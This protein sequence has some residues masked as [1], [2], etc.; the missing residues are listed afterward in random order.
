[1]SIT[2]I[3]KELKVSR[4][5]FSKF[6]QEQGYDTNPKK[7]KH[8][9]NRR[10]F[11]DIDTEEKLY[12]LGFLFADGCILESKKNGKKKGMVMEVTVADVDVEHLYKLCDSIGASRDMV[13]SKTVKL[14]DKEYV[15]QRL[16][17]CSTEMCRDLISHGI[18]PR[19]TRSCSI[20]KHALYSINLHHFIRGFFDGDGHIID[21]KTHNYGLAI[22][23]ASP[24]L[25]VQLKTIFA[26]LGCDDVS[27][28]PSSLSTFELRYHNMHDDEVILRYM[29]EGANIYLTRKYETFVARLW[30][31]PEVEGSKNG[32]AV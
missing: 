15:A 16:T 3:S 6:L 20:P 19:K 29:Y 18:Y 5:W 4:A 28:T 7:F 1:M 11:K 14:G 17:L 24:K 13:K 22:S 26:N 10:Y 27:I 30:R 12:W 21:N 8:T 2:K 23:S 31:N 9:F 25:L 32:E